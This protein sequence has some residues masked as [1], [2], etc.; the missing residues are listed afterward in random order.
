MMNARLAYTLIWDEIHVQSTN[1]GPTQFGGSLM[2][3]TQQKEKSVL[4]NVLIAFGSL[5]S[6]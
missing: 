1:T 6:L 5:I 3:F 2:N 4:E